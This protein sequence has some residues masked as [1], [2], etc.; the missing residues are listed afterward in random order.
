MAKNV[1]HFTATSGT[2]EA[3]GI[4]VVPYGTRAQTT[5]LAGPR[6]EV[7]SVISRRELFKFIKG[8]L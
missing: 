3:F 6:F 1:H 4:F 7:S 8:T 5:G 2:S